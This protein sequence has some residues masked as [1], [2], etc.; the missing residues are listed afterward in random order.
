MKFVLLKDL[1]LLEKDIKL[2]EVCYGLNRNGP[3]AS[4]IRMFGHWGKVLLQRV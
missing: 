3:I 2:L 1:R 4:Y